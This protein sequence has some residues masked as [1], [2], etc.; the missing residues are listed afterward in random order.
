MSDNTE[1]GEVS[2]KFISYP[3]GCEYGN[4][5]NKTLEYTIHDRDIGLDDMLQEFQYF[6]TGCGYQIPVDSSIE[7]VTD[8]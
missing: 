1:V 7:V 8:E 3:Y 2:Y 5:V 4:S 6:L